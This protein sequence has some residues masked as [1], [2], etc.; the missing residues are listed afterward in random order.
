MTMQRGAL[1]P[2][3]LKQLEIVLH[4]LS[5]LNPCQNDR[6]CGRFCVRLWTRYYVQKSAICYNILLGTRNLTETTGKGEFSKEVVFSWDRGDS[7]GCIQNTCVVCRVPWITQFIW[8]FL[9]CFLSVCTTYLG[10]RFFPIYIKIIIKKKITETIPS[11]IHFLQCVILRYPKL[12][13]LWLATWERVI[14]VFPNS[15]THSCHHILL[16]DALKMCKLAAGWCMA[17]SSLSWLDRLN[18]TH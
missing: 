18:F 12:M 5:C 3:L 9:P 4:C 14:S 15:E 13:Y 1:W 16:M 11:H 8:L 6:Y 7:V 2:E 10:L 17:E